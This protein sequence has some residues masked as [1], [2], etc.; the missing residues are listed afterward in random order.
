M[1]RSNLFAA[2]LRDF[3]LNPALSGSNYPT[4]YGESVDAQFGPSTMRPAF[5]IGASHVSKT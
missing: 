1:R 2:K 5:G 4:N 3:S